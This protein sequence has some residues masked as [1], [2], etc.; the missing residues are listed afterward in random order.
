MR[1]L[2]ADGTDSTTVRDT[3][4]TL[5]VG[6]NWGRHEKA[7]LREERAADTRSAS[8]DRRAED[9]QVVHA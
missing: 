7:E 6:R 3:E 2:E 9:T 8:L 4:P 1:R 5:G